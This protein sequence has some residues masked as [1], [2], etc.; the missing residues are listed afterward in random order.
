MIV[1]LPASAIIVASGLEERDRE[2]ATA[3]NK[4]L[5][6]VQSLAAQQEQITVATKQMLCTLAQLPEVRSLNAEACN[7][8]FRALNDRAPFYS[9]IAAATSD[10]KVIA[11]S[12]PLERG[13]VNLADRW[14]VREAIRTR[15]FSAGEYIVG[16]VSKTPSLNYSYPV[17]DANKNLIA[18]IIAGFKLEEYAHFI[19]AVN[20]P[21]NS[22]LAITDH[23]GVGLYVERCL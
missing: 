19:R 10:G 1:F 21:E 23:A 18:I 5:L 14:H 7:K 2:L 16:R 20:L 15:D 3:S 6:L 17:I 9:S 13:G 8:L 4:A 11:A 12:T 22:S